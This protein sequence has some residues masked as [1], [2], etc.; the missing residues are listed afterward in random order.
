MELTVDMNTMGFKALCEELAKIS[1]KDFEDVVRFQA[2]AV[3]KRVMSKTKAANPAKLRKR[4]KQVA[5]LER[6]YFPQRDGTALIIGTSTK[7]RFWKDYS[8]KTDK[9]TVY[10]INHRRL[11]GDVW[12]NYRRAV[13]RIAPKMKAFGKKILGARGLAKQTWL[14]IAMAFGVDYILKAPAYIY[15]AKSTS[16]K[17]YRN[18][19]GKEF[20]TMRDAYVVMKQRYKKLTENGFAAVILQAAIRARI[21]AFS[22][23]VNRSVF[24][25][26]KKRAS[27]YPG[28]FVTE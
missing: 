25:D 23:D 14:N 16:K 19:E 20:F 6:G 15:K 12:E 11:P 13:A 1:G 17:I 8:P 4:A 21:K 10:P 3:L 7:M 22:T 24:K 26:A 18:S 2:G 28:V 27:R 5:N 9:P